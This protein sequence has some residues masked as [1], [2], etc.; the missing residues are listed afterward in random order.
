[1]MCQ[2]QHKGLRRR[3]HRLSSSVLFLILL[4]GA[5]K[6]ANDNDTSLAR[7]KGNIERRHTVA[8][9]A[10]QAMEST[11]V[12]EKL[13]RTF[14]SFTDFCASSSDV[15]R[16]CSIMNVSSCDQYKAEGGFASCTALTKVDAGCNAV[17]RYCT[18][19][20]DVVLN[21]TLNFSP[22]EKYAELAVQNA[23]FFSELFHHQA[24]PDG[25][26][27]ATVSGTG[28]S[29]L[30]DSSCDDGHDFFASGN[31]IFQ[32]RS[33]ITILSDPMVLG[34]GLCLINGSL[35]DQVSCHYTA[36]DGNSTDDLIYTAHDLFPQD[37]STT[38]GPK[39][40]WFTVTRDRIAELLQKKNH[41]ELEAYHIYFPQETSDQFDF[42]ATR[43]GY[44]P[45]LWS[46]P[47]YDC[48]LG[49]RLMVTYSA[50][51]LYHND[52]QLWYFGIT[53][54][55]IDLSNIPFNQCSEDAVSTE[56]GAGNGFEKIFTDT[57]LCEPMSTV[58]KPKDIRRF[59]SG[60]YTCQCRDGFYKPNTKL[61]YFE[62]S[63]LEELDP[64]DGIIAHQLNATAFERFVQ[65]RSESILDTLRAN[66]SCLPCPPGCDTCVTGNEVCLYKKNNSITRTLTAFT[67]ATATVAVILL[68]LVILQRYNADIRDVGRK[69]L[70]FI[71]V[72]S[73]IGYANVIMSGLRDATSNNCATYEWL[74]SLAFAVCFGAIFVKTWRL[75][76]FCSS[77]ASGCLADVYPSIHLG[78]I[79]SVTLIIFGVLTAKS[80][81]EP[82]DATNSA[83]QK[84]KT[85][86][87]TLLGI[88]MHGG[89]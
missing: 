85:C 30:A 51:M 41:T 74:R 40:P 4:V 82:R 18:K 42:N 87:T 76:R 84:Y 26:Y 6:A 81:F 23:N 49:P 71:V 69:F 39:L 78:I 47:Y 24:L 83:G 34:V 66:Y 37:S 60:L 57:Y 17:N 12:H 2:E 16:V 72:G 29:S 32:T 36:R 70:V 31:I 58:C 25:A 73:L 63:P 52:N 8:A 7:L 79:I 35:T 80:D 55:D 67:L 53:S 68:I 13:S 21:S 44:D 46:L 61:Q 89:Q 1:M 86:K 77:S 88:V 33:R 56:T 54:I 10:L 14:T 65:E 45:N 20:L 62:G 38:S 75:W 15:S 59:E 43:V 5:S 3:V 64:I 48:A 19:C 28:E 27:P 50:P 9:K 11:Q 22:Y